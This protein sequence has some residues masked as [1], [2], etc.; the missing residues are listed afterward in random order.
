MIMQHGYV[1]RRTPMKIPQ[2]ATLAPMIVKFGANC[3][4]MTEMTMI[5]TT[6]KTTVVSS[7]RD[8]DG[9]IWMS[10][11]RMA[12]P[13]C[14]KLLRACRGAADEEALIARGCEDETIAKKI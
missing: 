14:E 7:R 5:T 8:I 3:A 10:R 9:I 11:F 12:L 6:I 13:R 1:T 4:Q 2:H